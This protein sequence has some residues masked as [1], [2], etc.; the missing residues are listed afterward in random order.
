MSQTPIQTHVSGQTP[1]PRCAVY[2]RYS[3][4]VQR[5][6]SIEDQIRNCRVAA[7]RNGWLILEEYIR[8]DSELTGRT[9]VG[10]QGLAELLKLATSKP[11]PFDLILI[12]D[13]S[14]F[15]RYLPDVLRESD[16]LA[17]YGVSLYFVSDRLDSRDEAFRFAYIIKGIGDEQY[18]RGLSEKVH[19][20]QEGCIRRGYTAGGACYGYRNIAIPDPQHAGR[21]AT[22]R[23]LGVEREIVPEEAAIV[24]RIMELRAMGRGYGS[25]C[26]KLNND[27][28]PAPERRYSGKALQGRWFP[29]AI[30]EICRNEIYHGVRVWNRTQFVFNSAEG[31]RRKRKRP[32]SEW[33]RIEVPSLRIISD[34]VWEK[35]QTVNQRGRDKTYGRRLGGMTR[36]ESSRNYVFSGLLTCGVCGG[37]F[38]VVGGKPPRVFYGCRNHRYRCSCPARATIQRDYLEQQLIA[39][40]SANLRRPELE[41]RLMNEFAAQLETRLKSEQ[42][43][44]REAES[45]S[46]KLQ[47]ERYELV[48]KAERLVDAIVQHGISSF[49]SAQLNTLESRLA[50]IDRMLILKCDTTL[51]SFTDEEI[52]EFLAGERQHFCDALA[53]DPE[54][55]KREIQKHIHKLVITPKE[56]L[57]GVMLEVTGDVHLFQGADVL[58]GV[59]MER[60]CQQ[61]VEHARLKKGRPASPSFLRIPLFGMHLRQKALVIQFSAKTLR[62]LRRLLISPSLECLMMPEQL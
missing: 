9:L 25:I 42:K 40:I 17:H 5:K 41:Q 58:L 48:K 59:S 51:P 46:S 4:E 16:R 7:E 62:A 14:R 57:S 12:D 54:L 10:R 6:T 31:T 60:N 21:G 22:V 32:P 27:G 23:V 50:E 45:N 39:A 33:V 11:R 55:A 8:S 19:R 2:A 13:T 61:Y 34:E 53:G 38:T 29:S 18:V 1:T 43:L 26:R 47:E 52:R 35:V 15:G 3:S 44:A 49:I 36:T 37:P 28:V 30:R 56:T 20:G 24:L